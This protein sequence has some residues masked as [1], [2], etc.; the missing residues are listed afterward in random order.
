MREP[1]RRAALLF[2]DSIDSLWDC[3]G[4]S[5]CRSS[6]SLRRA[7]AIDRA[8]PPI[9]G[10]APRASS[11]PGRVLPRPVW[12]LRFPKICVSSIEM[13]GVLFGENT[14]FVCNDGLVT[15]AGLGGVSGLLVLFGSQLHP[16]C[17]HGQPI[18]YAI[19]D[20][21]IVLIL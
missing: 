18:E 5:A 6:A 21:D 4:S 10:G 16:C 9:Q 1:L 11:R 13:L 8:R 12:P 17:F 14:V 2:A 20:N 19:V 3:C 7:F 15:C